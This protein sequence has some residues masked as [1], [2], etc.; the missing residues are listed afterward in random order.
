MLAGGAILI[1]VH[2]AGEFAGGHIDGAVNVPLD[3]LA[4]SIA[5]TAPDPT[6]PI[7]F[8]GTRCIGV[9][10]HFQG[11]CHPKPVLGVDHRTNPK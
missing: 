6:Q 2:G 1:D 10:I 4:G 3:R 7:L 11:M 8:S 9:Q 5:R